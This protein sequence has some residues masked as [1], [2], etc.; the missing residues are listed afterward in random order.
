MA[1]AEG[2]VLNYGYTATFPVLVNIDNRPIYLLS[3]KDSAGLIKMYAMVDAQDY[4]QVYTVKASSNAEEA[5]NELILQ[6]GSTSVDTAD[7]KE[8]TI[9][10]K[11]INQ[12]VI[13]GSTYIYLNTDKGVYYLVVTEDNASVALFLKEGDSI[14]VK[15]L[16][17]GENY[18]IIS[19]EK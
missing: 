7:L 2:E 3:L 9:S 1:S 18:L 11:E 5:I 12:A 14:K 13:E 16:A 10:V 4:Q 19:L 15:S 8:E 17:S 6:L